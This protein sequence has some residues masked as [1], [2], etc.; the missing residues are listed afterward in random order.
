M[1]RSRND[2]PSNLPTF[3][4][5]AY[6]HTQGIVL[7][8]DLTLKIGKDYQKHANAG[9]DLGTDGIWSA[10]M[11]F[12]QLQFLHDHMPSTNEDAVHLWINAFL[13]RV[14]A[15][16]DSD[17]DKVVFKLEYGD[18]DANHSDEELNSGASYTHWT[19]MTMSPNDAQAW[20]DLPEPQIP[21]GSMLS[22]SEGPPHRLGTQIP[23]AAFELLTRARRIQKS[24]IR[25]VLTNGRE[26][27]FLILTLDAKSGGRCF[28]SHRIIIHQVVNCHE[29]LSRESVSNVAAI[30]AYWAKH[31]HEAYDPATDPFFDV[32]SHSSEV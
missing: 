29:A 22:V 9:D 20:L 3:D 23:Q 12:K 5:S 15:M 1:L 25:G 13:C 7:S 8:F 6:L 16:G 30:L 21:R 28:C 32:E 26:W 4:P 31:S 24:T 2:G 17:E 27:I 18:T 14:A 10:D 19:V 11:L